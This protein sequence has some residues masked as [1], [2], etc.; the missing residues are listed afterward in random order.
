[1]LELGVLWEEYGLVGNIVVFIE[2]SLPFYVVL[3][4]I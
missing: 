2:Q 4:A 3:H 1:M